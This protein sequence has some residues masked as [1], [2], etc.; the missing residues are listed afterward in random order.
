MPLPRSN[1]SRRV[2]PKRQLSEL[3]LCYS[4]GPFRVF[5]LKT[6]E[7]QVYAT[8]VDGEILYLSLPARD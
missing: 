4:C 7:R 5:R 3:T 1:R 2:T 6:K 8:I